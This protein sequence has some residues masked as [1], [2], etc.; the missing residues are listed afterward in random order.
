MVKREFDERGY[1][2]LSK[3]YHN[4]S[5]K[6]QYICPKHKD[7]GILEITFA[8]FTMGKGCVYCGG[9]ARKTHEEYVAELNDKKPFIYPIDKYVSLKTPIKH[10]CL[11]CGY[12]WSVIPDNLLNAPNG[13]PRCG[14]REW[15]TKDILIDRIH[16][17]DPSIIVTGEYVNTYSKMS[18]KCS[19][20]GKEW[21]AKP[22]N[23]LNGKWCPHCKSSKG[24]LKISLVLDDLGIPYEEQKRFD[25]CK[26]K[27]VLPFDFYIESNNACIEYDGLQ[28]YEPCTFGGISNDEANKSFELTKIK[29]DIKTEYCKNHDIKLLRIPYWEY[30]NME[31]LLLSFIH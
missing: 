17:I 6:L 23:V 11:I 18:F 26:Y 16:K 29:D 8:N 1:E 9:R 30:N 31:N 10:K 27:S 21:Y 25:D 5:Q 20:C 14:K 15:L 13:C 12:I 24:E 4:N 19:I 22:N 2:L 28:H 7:K 3:E